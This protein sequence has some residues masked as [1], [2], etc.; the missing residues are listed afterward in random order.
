MLN[1]KIAKVLKIYGI[2]SLTGAVESIKDEKSYENREKDNNFCVMRYEN[3]VIKALKWEIFKPKAETGKLRAE[4]ES[5]K[6]NYRRFD[7]S[8]DTR[9]PRQHQRNRNKQQERT[10]YNCNKS[11]HIARFCREKKPKRVNSSTVVVHI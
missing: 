5:I 11:G 10:C 1:R 9:Y 7:S 3:D 4:I 2:V 8:K 6:Q